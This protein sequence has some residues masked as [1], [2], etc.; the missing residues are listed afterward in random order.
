MIANCTCAP[1]TVS[2]TAVGYNTDIFTWFFG[3]GGDTSVVVNADPANPDTVTVTVTYV[4]QQSGTF[5]PVLRL[6]DQ[7]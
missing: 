7:L 3:D 6:E 2:F 1:C 5:Y 4:Y